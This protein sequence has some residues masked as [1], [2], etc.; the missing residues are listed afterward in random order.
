MKTLPAIVVLLTLLSPAA[1]A[2]SSAW[3]SFLHG[4]ARDELD[5]AVQLIEAEW[6]AAPIARNAL[7]EAIEERYVLARSENLG[8]DDYAELLDEIL[9]EPGAE[10]DDS[11]VDVSPRRQ[12]ARILSEEIPLPGT[13]SFASARDWLAALARREGFPVGEFDSL[14]RLAE[15]QVLATLSTL[16][17]RQFS[18]ALSV[19]VANLPDDLSADDSVRQRFAMWELLVLGAEDVGRARLLRD[20]ERAMID[21][22]LAEARDIAGEL[23]EIRIEREQVMDLH[24]RFPVAPDV[25][26]LVS[27]STVGDARRLSESTAILEL[28]TLLVALTRADSRASVDVYQGR[29]DAAFLVDTLQSLLASASDL[30]RFAVARAM[31]ISRAELDHAAARL[32]RIRSETARLPDSQGDPSAA[33]GPPDSAFSLFL[34]AGAEHVADARPWAV[35]DRSRSGDSYRWAMLPIVSHPYSQYMIATLPELSDTRVMVEDFI[36]GVYER[37][38]RSLDVES[39][40]ISAVVLGDGIQPLSRVY[41]SSS[42]AA[43]AELYESFAAVAQGVEELSPDFLVPYTAG[44]TL[45]GYWSHMHGLHVAV[46]ADETTDR[47]GIAR[48]VR[49]RVDGWFALARSVDTEQEELSLT[50]RGLLALRRVLHDE[51]LLVVSSAG[52]PSLAVYEPRLPAVLSLLDEV[53]GFTADPLVIRSKLAELYEAPEGDATNDLI[54]AD[55]ARLLTRLRDVEIADRRVLRR[56][57]GSGER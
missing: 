45:A 15:D 52:I 37:T 24:A 41:G 34:Q 23:R 19:P 42:S 9:P 39:D 27:A 50:L 11:S 5:Q 25:F 31:G 46:I 55:L 8:L 1:G 22:S 30:Q 48:L 36:S 17:A 12:I 20:V 4:E 10:G 21:V 32:Y 28:S 16:E 40:A 2:Q 7:Y 56:L 26:A 43:A 38:V 47:E 44:L 57:A 51:L 49:A 14:L 6:T 33:T 54:A 13:R 35:G 18:E 3:T 53:A 29:G